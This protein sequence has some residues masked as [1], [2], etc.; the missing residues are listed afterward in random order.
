VS[1]SR[2]FHE[3]AARTIGALSSL[4]SDWMLI[5]AI[6]VAAWGQPRATTDADFAASL[7]FADADKLDQA[8]L[9]H[10]LRKEKGPIE[11]PQKRLIL[12]K[13]W[14]PETSIGIDVFYTTGYVTGEFQKQALK[15][16]TP[17]TF[18]GRTYPIASPE[19][20]TIYKVLAY[21]QKDLDDVGTILERQFQKLDWAY[22]RNWSDKL[23]IL[24]LLTDVLTQYLQEQGLPIR[25]PW[26]P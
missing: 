25:M 4:N 17:V 13:Y 19:D 5:G 9:A 7:D 12:S 24:A 21:R 15:R 11:I 14:D 18:D 26:E 3:A 16:K 23:G 10:G 6:P 8:A 22:V 2:E 1:F 20:L